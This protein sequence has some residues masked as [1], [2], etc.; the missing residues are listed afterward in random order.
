MKQERGGDFRC[1]CGVRIN[2][3]RDQE[4]QTYTYFHGAGEA[5]MVFAYADLV[6]WA[7]SDLREPHPIRAWC[8]EI[9]RYE[10]TKTSTLRRSIPPG[11]QWS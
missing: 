9:H 4:L 10:L 11:Q 5:V 8:E 1:T 3:L 7:R 6:A 2:L